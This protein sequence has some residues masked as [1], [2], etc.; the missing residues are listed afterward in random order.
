MNSCVLCL[1]LKIKPHGVCAQVLDQLSQKIPTPVRKLKGSYQ[2]VPIE[3]KP[4]NQEPCV[5]DN[6]DPYLYHKPVIF[7]V[8][9]CCLPGP[10]SASLPVLLVSIVNCSLS[11]LC[12][13]SNNYCLYANERQ[14]QPNPV[15]T[16]LQIASA[17]LYKWLFLLFRQ[18][19]EPPPSTH[20]PN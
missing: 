18:R 9:L 13:N 4:V 15:G 8:S 16:M 7:T 11:S 2:N 5:S 10:E 19:T 12:W 17:D 3:S 6:L 1:D 20:Y 14:F